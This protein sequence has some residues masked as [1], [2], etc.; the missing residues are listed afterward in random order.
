[1]QQTLS[2][3]TRLLHWFI[4]IFMI[5]LA[6]V[7]LYM[8]ET[9]AYE[10]YPIHKAIGALIL[11]VTLIRVIW[12]VIEGWPPHLASIP[13][14]QYALAK[15]VHWVLILATVLMPISGMMMSIAGGHGLDIFGWEV[16]AS[17]YDPAT[18]KAIPL[19]GTMAGI[20][21]EVHEW[22][23]KILIGAFILHFVGALKHH[24]IDKDTTLKRMLRG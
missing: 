4:A 22:L 2:T 18:Q 7:G 11:G 6:A 15:L 16:A 24:V 20:G 5:V 9:K 12:R 21:H 23:G 13:A 14:W 19:N 1:M 3:P 10:L 8:A 17:N